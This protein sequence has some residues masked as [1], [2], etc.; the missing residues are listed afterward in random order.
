M[1]EAAGFP[2]VYLTAYFGMNELAHPRKGQ[3]ILVHSAAGGVGGALVQLGKIAGCTVVGIVG[4]SHKVATVKQLGADHVIDKSKTNWIEEIKK[5]DV[6]G[7]DGFDVVFDAN[8]VETLWKSYELMASGGKLIVYGFHTMLPRTGGSPNWL[9]LAWNWLWTPSF[10]PLQ[11][12]GANKSV[13]A[14]NL[15]YL[16]HKF[17]IFTE[18]MEQLL[19]HFDS[20]ALKPP[21]VTVYEDSLEQIRQA[22]IDIESG[23]TIGKL[24]VAIKLPQE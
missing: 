1:E 8:G 18:F 20:G 22:H 7:G 5:L 4:S 3:W 19:E 13:M 21:K 17:D 11:M 10:S 23:M 2:A 9:K 6:N 16:F 24:V 14:F 12:T 15:S